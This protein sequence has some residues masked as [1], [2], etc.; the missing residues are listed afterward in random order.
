MNNQSDTEYYLPRDIARLLTVDRLKK[1]KNLGLILDKY[2]PQSAVQKSE[3]KG[4]WLKDIASE[5]Y[6]DARLVESLYRR[7]LSMTTAVSSLHFNASLD[8]RMAVGLGGETV[9]E[10]D[11]TLHHL[12]GI[13]YIPGSALK[14]LTKAYVTGEV[15]PSKKIDDDN[16]IV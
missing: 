11:L 2:P 4:S 1:C 6:I 14:G 10:T 9:L 5:S 12:Y 15:H 16:E 8:W 3:G 13:P 7:W